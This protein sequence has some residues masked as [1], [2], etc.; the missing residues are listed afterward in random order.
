M[1]LFHTVQSQHWAAGG[2]AF[3]QDTKLR[4][5][6]SGEALFEEDHGFVCTY[7]SFP[8]DS[9][10]SWPSC[11]KAMKCFGRPVTVVL[12]GRSQPI[13]AQQTQCDND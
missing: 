10:G 1:G 4:I 6:Q 2:A 8:Q 13:Y 5:W 9:D 3:Q 12:F 11:L 7:T